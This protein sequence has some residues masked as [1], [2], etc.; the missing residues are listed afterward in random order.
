[1]KK[2]QSSLIEAFVLTLTKKLL[3]SKQSLSQSSLIEAFVLT[4]TYEGV[5]LQQTSLNPL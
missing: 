5:S 2:S 4:Y 1:M 3:S